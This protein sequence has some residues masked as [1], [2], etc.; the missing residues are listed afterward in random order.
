MIFG[1]PLLNC[2]RLFTSLIV[3]RIFKWHFAEM[4]RVFLCSSSFVRRCERYACAL[5]IKM[6]FYDFFFFFLFSC[7]KHL[8]AR[9]LLI[10]IQ[11]KHNIDQ[12]TFANT[13]NQLIIIETAEKLKKNWNSS[14][15]SK[16]NKLIELI[17]L[18]V[19]DFFLLLSSLVSQKT[20]FSYA[21]TMHVDDTFLHGCIVTELL[22][23]NVFFLSSLRR[24]TM[25]WSKH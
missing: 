24:F 5:N 9:L 16:D 10:N 14:L 20:L 1:I 6:N 7:Q 17:I 13:S 12:F 21:C 18:L 4:M 25:K 15:P 22:N 8:S 2:H 23:F 11:S 3:W 19:C